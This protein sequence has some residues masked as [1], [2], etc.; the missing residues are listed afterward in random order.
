MEKIITLKFTNYYVTGEV[1]V[2]LWDGS[3]GYLGMKPYYVDSLDDE[4]LIDGIND[5]GFGVQDIVSAR[6]TIFENYSGY[7]SYLTEKDFDLVEL[8]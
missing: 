2:I 1:D 6:L 8:D 4:T 3:E 7:K 5:N